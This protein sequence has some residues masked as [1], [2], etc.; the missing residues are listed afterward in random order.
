MFLVENRWE[1][2]ES[3]GGSKPQ[4]RGFHCCAVVDTNIYFFGGYNGR[5]NFNDI[6]VFDTVKQEWTYP[7]VHGVLPVARFEQKLASLGSYLFL[8]GGGS[9]VGG[10]YLNSVH[11]LDTGSH[12]VHVTLLIIVLETQTW[13][14]A[15]ACG[16]VPKGRC[17]HSF[18]TVNRSIVVHGGF[19]G[20]SRLKDTCI[21][22]A[23]NAAWSSATS[24]P[25]RRA[26][27]AASTIGN[28]LYIYGGYDGKQRLNDVHMLNIGIL[29]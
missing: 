27:H 23:E 29:R 2:L 19:D 18:T 3:V 22:S 4:G 6:F 12:V 8:F 13:G 21:L 25:Q 5:T 7:S 9:V 24:L 1:C 11:V 20:S 10:Q 17:A 26:A 15:P 14:V 16:K 28:R